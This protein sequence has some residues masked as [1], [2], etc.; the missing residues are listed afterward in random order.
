M[1]G[2]PGTA[3]ALEQ[4]EPDGVHGI[5]SCMRWMHECAAELLGTFA[6]GEHG[7]AK[8][9]SPGGK[10]LAENRRALRQSLE[11]LGWTLHDA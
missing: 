10:L 7:V 11:Q 4:H 5:D 6:F 8:S 9:G 2:Q 1:R 3:V